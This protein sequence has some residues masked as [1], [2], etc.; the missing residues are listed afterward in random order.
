MYALPSGNPTMKGSNRMIG[1]GSRRGES[2]L[3]AF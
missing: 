3:R 1:H 2:D